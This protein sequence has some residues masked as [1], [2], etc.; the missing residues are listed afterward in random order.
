V[1]RA[2]PNTT[3]R[4]LFVVG[5]GRCGSTLFS[6]MIRMHPLILSV[7]EWF[8]V[9]GE[10]SAAE[11]APTDAGAFWRLLT[12]PTPDVAELVE[13]Y[14]ALPELKI[15]AAV[16]SGAA[17][18]TVAPILL[19]PLPHLAD[20]SIEALYELR[21]HIRRHR[22]G[23]LAEWHAS[24]LS[25]LARRQGKTT[26]LERSGGSL[27]YVDSLNRSW[28]NARY[29]HLY[30]DG[31]E[32][33]KSM[34]GH[35]YFRVR[36]ARAI[37]RAPVAIQECLERRIPVEQFGAYWSAVVLRGLG[38]LKKIAR[39]DVLHVN[40]SELV[41][42]PGRVLRRVQ[43]FLDG[44]IEAEDWVARAVTLVRPPGSRVDTYTPAT[45]DGLRRVCKI[46]MREIARLEAERE[47]GT[48]PSHT[49]L[50]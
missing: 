3:W 23:R 26:W 28:P 13:R 8:T 40:Y 11:D 50:A 34:Y 2:A 16:K 9:L 38:V 18:R 35:P 33:A 41:R 47:R 37:A 31:V 49:I 25:F 7:S 45:T 39:E 42:D 17:S 5:T 24:A 15:S 6:D 36:V 30:R 32:C 29:I 1:N 12:I 46:G 21:E 44:S 20:D 19:I 27:A 48:D 22:A 4:P 14:P 10:R 43:R